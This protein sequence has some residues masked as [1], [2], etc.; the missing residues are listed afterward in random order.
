MPNSGVYWLV[1][2]NNKPQTG[3]HELSE[4]EIS[5][6]GT[7]IMAQQP[8]F[9]PVMMP[10]GRQKWQKQMEVITGLAVLI[11]QMAQVSM[12]L[13]G[14]SENGTTIRTMLEEPLLRH[15]I[16]MTIPNE[17]FLVVYLPL[18]RPTTDRISLK[19]LQRGE[20]LDIHT[21]PTFP[22]RARTP[23]VLVGIGALLP[24]PGCSCLAGLRTLLPRIGAAT[25][26]SAVSC[27]HGSASSW[28]LVSC[29]SGGWIATQRRTGHIFLRP[30]SSFFNSQSKI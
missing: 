22:P 19:P 23:P 18:L 12:T 8:H 26:A 9:H 28:H 20:D 27:R 17:P 6:A 25:L 5:L 2:S 11:S 24:M 3:P 1:I 21:M 16:P 10:S 14:I 30:V 4:A 13:P 15:T 7:R 29:I